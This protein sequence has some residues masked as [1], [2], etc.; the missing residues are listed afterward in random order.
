M[1][2]DRAGLW[3]KRGSWVPNNPN[4]VW[5]GE[6]WRLL[7]FPGCFKLRRH[8]QNSQAL[9]ARGSL[10]TWVGSR[11]GSWLGGFRRCGWSSQGQGHAEWVL[12][13]TGPVWEQKGCG[14]FE[15]ILS[16]SGGWAGQRHPAAPQ[17]GGWDEEEGLSFRTEAVA[18]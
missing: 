9:R 18:A 2:V 3:A 14:N 7:K 17:G 11:M 13:G 5:G 6:R 1:R 15:A 10:Q 16:H 4:E 12:R 8:R